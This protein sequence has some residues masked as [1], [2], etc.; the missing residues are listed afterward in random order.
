M[1]FNE[2]NVYHNSI[3]IEKTLFILNYKRI[4]YNDR[5]KKRRRF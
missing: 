5:N 4:N 3:T 1:H 2:E